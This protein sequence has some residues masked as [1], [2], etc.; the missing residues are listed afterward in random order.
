MAKTKK[1]L[2]KQRKQ[3]NI[4]ILTIIAVI[5]IVVLAIGVFAVSKFNKMDKVTINPEQI[6]NEE[7]SEETQT[8]MSGYTDI[9]LFGLDNRKTGNYAWGNSDVIMVVS[10]NNDTKEVAMVSVYRDTYLDISAKGE[11]ARFR[12]ANAA[13]A[14]G[15]AEQALFMLN[16]NLDLNIDEYIA[17][18]FQAVA[19]AIDL[20]GGIEIELTE[21]EVKYINKYIKN[22]NNILDKASPEIS[23]PGVHT[24]DG[25]QSV[26]YSRIR[27]TS[28]GD[29]KRA[30]RQR[31]VI[32]AALDKAKEA[33][34]KTLNN[35]VDVVFPEIETTMSAISLL[36]M[37]SVLMDYDL[38]ESYGF[39]FDR[40]T[41]SHSSKGSIVVPC[42]LTSNVIELHKILYDDYDY[43]PSAQ[44]ERYNEYI[45]N[46]TGKTEKSA[47]NDQFT[48]DDE[49]EMEEFE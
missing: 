20:L 28:G 38:S 17:F 1:N 14:N 48:I 3:R 2:S 23:G 45:I 10:I 9:A 44:V 27:Y 11:D 46:D 49:I 30:Q 43:T 5:A 36:Q 24:L 42:T 47:I 22:T 6:Q 7:L 15:G 32:A 12:K 40:T 21:A 41:M 19:D 16:N 33:D 37:M 26:A 25:V 35:I 13:Y 29:F 31:T 4:I 18:D 34:L 39:P 8:V